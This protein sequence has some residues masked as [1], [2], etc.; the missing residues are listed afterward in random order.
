MNRHLR[1]LLSGAGLRALVYVTA[2]LIGLFLTPYLVKTLGDRQ[3]AVFVFAGL[4]TSW[5]GLVDFGMTTASARFDAPI[6]AS[7]EKD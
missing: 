3:Y 6:F 1:S 2:V 7:P 5:C 4:F